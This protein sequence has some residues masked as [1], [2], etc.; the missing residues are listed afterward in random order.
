MLIYGCGILFVLPARTQTFSQYFYCFPFPKSQLSALTFLMVAF[1]FFL[2]CSALRVASQS[3]GFV[4]L[5]KFQEVCS[6]KPSM[7]RGSLL[8]L[9]LS[10]WYWRRSTKSFGFS[11]NCGRT[12]GRSCLWWSMCERC[13]FPIPRWP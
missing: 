6:A 11:T 10:L 9:F 3:V 8:D 1:C 12:F 4:R 7:I 5:L 13:V 2:L